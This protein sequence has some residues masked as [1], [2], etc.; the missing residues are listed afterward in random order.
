MIEEMQSLLRI[1]DATRMRARELW[2]LLMPRVDAI[3]ED[4]YAQLR[5]AGVHPGLTDET[6]ARLKVQQRQ[7]WEKL[8]H[9]S[10]DRDY[11]N[12]LRRISI[13]HRDIDLSVGWYV[14]GYMALK[15]KFNTV[16]VAS[17]LAPQ[18]QLVLMDVLDR[19]VTIDMSLALSAFNALVID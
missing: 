12:S 17:D 19:Y 7:H 3:I 15:S 16:I 11:A 4:F 6:I 5:S 8:F 13:R 10:F 9:S 1:D 2:T 18:D 14:A